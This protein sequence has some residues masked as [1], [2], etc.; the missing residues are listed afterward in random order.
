MRR[1]A[2]SARTPSASG[3]WLFL[4]ALVLTLTGCP[5]T[6]AAEAP[7]PD[8]RREPVVEPGRIAP[9]A[10][11]H[12]AEILDRAQEAF[13][14]GR[15]G[16]ARALAREVVDRYP[17][18]PVSGRALLLQARAALESGRGSEADATAER[19][20]RLLPE[21]DP[22]VAGVRVLQ[23]RA[24]L[25]AEEPLRAVN[26]LMAMGPQAPLN[27]RIRGRNVLREA[28]RELGREEIASVLG[29]GPP[30]QVLLPVVQARYAELLLAAG[31]AEEARRYAR[32]ALEAGAASADSLLAAA[33]L[34]GELARTDPGLERERAR[35]GIGT[36]L[37]TGGSPALRDFAALIAEGV[38]VAAATAAE[39]G[40]R[41]EVESRDD[42]G[43]PAVAAAAVRELEGTSVL[44]V[45]GLLEDPVLTAAARG[46]RGPLPLTSP[47]ARNAP[48]GS[49]G[50]YALDGPNPEAAATVAR[51]AAAQGFERVAMV[52]S[53]APESQVEADAF[54]AVLRGLGVP[55]VG[56]F[57]YEMGAT[58]F[59]TQLLDAQDA[60]RAAEI[61]ALELG[62][63]DTLHVEELD[64]V[65]LFVPIPPEDVEYLAPQIT[66][67]GLDTLA[68]AVLGTSGWTDGEVLET[69]NTRHTSGVVATAPVSAGR[70]SP[71]YRRFQEAYEAHFQRSLVS[72]VP[73]LGY[74]AALLLLEAARAGARTPR[75][76]RRALER[77]SALEGATGTF[78]VVGG[79][80]TRQTQLVQVE[81]GVLIPIR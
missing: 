44:G 77:I 8:L 33:V 24:A 58:S 61:A 79:R 6:P 39:S 43:D 76:V 65:A 15:Y 4:P 45:V 73:A 20:M 29:A 56:R 48:E 1:A 72:S 71:G 63:D 64:P 42:Q 50:V 40:L 22:R 81:H 13:E 17:S 55:V 69:V 78:Q 26:R 80:V 68:V 7:G 67:F 21:G 62:E 32:A 75:E 66:H 25:A 34:R 37:P 38:E 3:R 14:D 52:H 23:A 46:R 41:V 12:A 9:V 70:G 27:A 28:S 19:Y 31:E 53:L 11:A 5:S 47:T 10:E 30:E 51:Y 74:D 16:E 35:V 49:D 60:L 59:G 36:V 57:S 18:A 54:E 2:P